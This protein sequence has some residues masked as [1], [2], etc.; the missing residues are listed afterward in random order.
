[1]DL[2]VAND[3]VIYFYPD[4]EEK[5]KSEELTACRLPFD[6]LT[7]LY[8][9]IFST[10][11]EAHTGLDTLEQDNTIQYLGIKKTAEGFT[12]TA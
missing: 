3:D 8:Y 1:M 12:I 9:L 4:T 2:R 7:L 10:V 11:R 5:R 6:G